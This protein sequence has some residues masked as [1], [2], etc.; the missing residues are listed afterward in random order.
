MKSVDQKDSQQP[1][2]TIDY[3]LLSTAAEKRSLETAGVIVAIINLDSIPKFLL[4]LAARSSADQATIDLDDLKQALDE[5]EVWL[6]REITP[7][8]DETTNLQSNLISPLQETRRWGETLISTL[9][10]ALVE[11]LPKPVFDSTQEKDST[12]VYVPKASYLG[13]GNLPH[14]KPTSESSL[15]YRADYFLLGC[16]GLQSVQNPIDSE[17]KTVG[18]MKIG[19]FLSGRV[20][21]DGVNFQRRQGGKEVVLRAKE[22]LLAFLA[23]YAQDPNTYS[24]TRD[25]ALEQY[26]QRSEKNNDFKRPFPQELSAAISSS[27]A[28]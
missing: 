23:T 28:T 10:G 11:E 13:S 15:N 1:R 20:N 5:V 19:D 26:Q 4:Q 7:K 17:T 18:W 16:K 22:K 6:I 21:T 9:S 25:Q 3:P 8:P 14:P 12:F 27:P 24:F 2:A